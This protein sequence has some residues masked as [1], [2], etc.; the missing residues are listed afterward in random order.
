MNAARQ[1]VVPAQVDEPEPD[2][3]EP[4][5]GSRGVEDFDEAETASVDSGTV[6]AHDPW[7]IAVPCS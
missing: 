3:A 2:S 6:G 1:H 7:P 4:Q 5:V